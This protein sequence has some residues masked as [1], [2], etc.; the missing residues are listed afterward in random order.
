MLKTPFAL[1]LHSK[2]KYLAEIAC[3]TGMNEY[4]SK[5]NKMGIS[6][7]F[8][9]LLMW[10]LCKLTQH[11]CCPVRHSADENC[12]APCS[13]SAWHATREP[14]ENHVDRLAVNIEDVCCFC[15]PEAKNTTYSICLPQTHPLTNLMQRTTS[16][17]FITF[18]VIR[19][20]IH[21]TSPNSNQLEFDSISY[22]LHI[23]YSFKLASLF[24]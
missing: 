8:L 1:F 22:Y 5:F 4:F 19:V 18:L 21:V 17:H 16:Q 10:N 2:P 12:S 6:H 9:H 15:E 13:F 3:K 11:L 7:R 24:L 23:I 20:E 14:C